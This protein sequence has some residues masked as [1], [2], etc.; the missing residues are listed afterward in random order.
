MY[1]SSLPRSETL[2]DSLFVL[3]YG[4][5]RDPAIG[6]ILLSPPRKVDYLDVHNTETAYLAIVLLFLVDYSYIICYEYKRARDKKVL[7]LSLGGRV[8]VVWRM[9]G[10]VCLR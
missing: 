2:S 5:F 10:G 6:K 4:Y 8:L 9:M 7:F 1:I 3:L